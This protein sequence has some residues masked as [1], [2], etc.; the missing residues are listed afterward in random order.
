M[1]SLLCDGHSAGQATST[2]YGQ[3]GGATEGSTVRVGYGPGPR[4]RGRDKPI[5]W[6]IS[7]AG[8]RLGIGQRQQTGRDCGG[9]AWHGVCLRYD[10]KGGCIG[11]EIE[12]R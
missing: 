11:N 7:T 10:V 2:R 3:W 6:L 1:P 5:D 9:S 12:H 4:R 8:G